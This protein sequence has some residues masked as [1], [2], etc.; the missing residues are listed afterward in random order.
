MGDCFVIRNAR[1]I[2]PSQ[3]LDQEISIVVENGKVRSL[4]G[5]AAPTT[6]IDGRGCIV[7]PGWIDAHV[8]VYEHCTPLGINADK[9]CLSRG[10]TTVVDAG[11]AGGHT[12]GRTRT[13][14]HT[15][16]REL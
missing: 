3:K 8:H 1:I 11:S 10:V 9:Y 14:T 4:G 16:A 13:R 6:V 2:D 5:D 15:C 7:T 12:H